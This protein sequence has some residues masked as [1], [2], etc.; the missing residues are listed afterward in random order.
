MVS[1]LSFFFSTWIFIGSTNVAFV[2]GL[3]LSIIPC[4]TRKT[5]KTRQM[6]ISK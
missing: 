5:A 1:P 4:D 3:K 2:Y 6:G